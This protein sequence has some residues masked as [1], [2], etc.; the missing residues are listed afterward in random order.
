MIFYYP[1]IHLTFL[2][3]K[4]INI[5]ITYVQVTNLPLTLNLSSATFYLI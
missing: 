5:Y 4:N 2:M 3:P 1:I